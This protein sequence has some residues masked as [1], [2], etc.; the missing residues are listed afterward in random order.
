[1]KKSSILFPALALLIVFSSCKKIKEAT[2]RDVIITPDAIEFTIPVITT[3]TEGT[4]TS[5]TESDFDLDE[6]IKSAA[7]EFGEDNIK[8]ITIQSVKIELLNSNT[9]N[10]I[11]NFESLSL[12]INAPGA[13]EATVAAVTA[14]P[15]EA[16]T[17][18]EIPITG[19]NELK[20]YLG[21]SSFTYTVKGRARTVTTI[22]L[23]AK[24]TAKYTFKVGL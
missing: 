21:A 2:Q 4:L 19:N 8:K 10:K 6:L 3:T 14:I 24:L 9:T 18:L 12:S 11:G 13:T 1:M 5:V 15:A 20:T 17:S 7:S 22:P 16:T 23:Q